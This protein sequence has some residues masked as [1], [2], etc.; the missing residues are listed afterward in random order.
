MHLKSYTY[1]NKITDKTPQEKT[2]N[3]RKEGFPKI[4]HDRNH[5]DTR[6][7]RFAVHPL[8]KFPIVF[9]LNSIFHFD[10]LFSVA[11]PR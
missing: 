7:T 9:Y 4:F 1:G 3:T 8:S 2:G 5:L 11:F 6:T 10:S